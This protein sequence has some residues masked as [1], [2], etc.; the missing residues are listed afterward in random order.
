[1]SANSQIKK[2]KDKLF[3]RIEL[4]VQKAKEFSDKYSEYSFLWTKNRKKFLGKVFNL[5]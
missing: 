3:E 1:M 5:I 4:G 2:M